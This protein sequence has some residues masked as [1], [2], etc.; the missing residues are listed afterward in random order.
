MASKYLQKF[1]VPE[2]FPEIL[3]DFARE[4]LRDQPKDILKYGF[5]YFKAKD[6]GNDFE[7]ETKGS[8][9]PPVAS[10]KSGASKNDLENAKNLKSKQVIKK[11]NIAKKDDHSKLK[12]ESIKQAYGENKETKQNSK[13]LNEEQK[14]SKESKKK[15]TKEEAHEYHQYPIPGKYQIVPCKPLENE[16]DLRLA[17]SPGVGF[18]CQ[19]IM[20]NPLRVYD[21]TSKA[22]SVC[23]ISN[24]TAVLGLGNIGALAGK[25]VMEGKGVLMKKFGDIN[26]VDLEVNTTNPDEFINCVKLLGS[27]FGGIN[28]EDIRG[29]DWFYIE[30]K[31]K[32]I[33][34][35]PVFHDDQH[36]TAIIVA[37]GLVNALKI[38]KKQI[39]KIKIVFNGA[40][41][42][43]I[44]WLQLVI[45]SGVSKN[46]A[47]LWDTSGVIYKGRK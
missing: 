30:N 13:N 41:A 16:L 46:N 1:S 2:S 6:E 3:H 32:E 33:M 39:D 44:A 31:L 11:E 35:I 18:P 26:G 45:D 4:I 40:G 47:I 42:A 36:G 28:L 19:E 12:N 7:Y 37:A 17:Y 23:V 24:G 34:N 27:S 29:P 25:P 9:I 15:V 20:K 38:T 5:E 21:Y 10:K 14:I 8:K 43:G 22:N